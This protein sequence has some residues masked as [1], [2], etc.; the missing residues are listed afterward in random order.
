LESASVSI[1][2]AAAEAS[3]LSPDVG[4][5]LL[6]AA[7]L[8]F[9]DGVAG[10]AWV[11]ALVTAVLGVLSF[12]VLRRVPSGQPVRTDAGNRDRPRRDW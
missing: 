5:A 4:E 12:T 8:G 9:T 7:C 10:A 6:E 1:P 11:G 2:A 3:R